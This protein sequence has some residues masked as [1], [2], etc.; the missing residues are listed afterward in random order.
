MNYNTGDSNKCLNVDSLL[1]ILRK[2]FDLKM[3]ERN[4]NLDKI[5]QRL[6]SIFGVPIWHSKLEKA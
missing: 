1:N 4:F 3:I 6:F 5:A 2:I